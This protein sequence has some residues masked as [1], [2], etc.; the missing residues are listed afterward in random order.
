MPVSNRVLY[1]HTAVPIAPDEGAG[2]APRQYLE[3]VWN[4]CDAL[5][6]SKSWVPSRDVVLPSAS[7]P[8]ED[9]RTIVIPE[10]ELD[11]RFRIVASREKPSSAFQAFAY[12][13]H[14]VF[15]TVVQ[16]DPRSSDAE[17]VEWTD[18]LRQWNDLMPGKVPDGALGETLVFAAIVTDNS[19]LN[20]PDC[21]YEAISKELANEGVKMLPGEYTTASGFVLWDGKD[22]QGRRVIA[23]LAEKPAARELDEF[24]EHDV[25][26]F[27]WYVHRRKPAPFGQYL[28]DASKV[29]YE[30]AAYRKRQALMRAANA[31][32]EKQI[33]VVLHENA[34]LRAMERTPD[35]GKATTH[36]A[37]NHPNTTR[38]LNAQLEVRDGQ[39]G[40]KGLAM[41]V[42]RLR[43]LR[44][45]LRIATRNMAMSRPDSAH[46][47][48]SWRGDLFDRD[49]DRAEWLQQQIEY[50]IEYAQ[51]TLERAEASHALTTLRVEQATDKHNHY[52]DRVLL[53]HS[54]TAG[55]LVGALTLVQWLNPET[56]QRTEVKVA[57]AVTFAAFLLAF[58][59]A[60]ARWTLTYRRLDQGAVIVFGGLFSWLVVT[61][62]WASA[63]WWAALFVLVGLSLG[64]GF[65]R[66]HDDSFLK[67]LHEHDIVVAEK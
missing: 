24:V 12:V 51:A 50:D 53:V 59:L 1:V 11:D 41:Q 5:L 38:L 33:A 47:A 15:G 8:D 23:V 29:S 61:L 16:L 32:V 63:G 45:T 64:Y 22:R 25:D 40:E 58:P 54:I 10:D 30:D 62:I 4:A 31:K 56:P 7:P 28:V 39:L 44:N 49:V 43:E 13:S 65:V 66:W 18:L 35:S 17:Q 26:P 42:A 20:D 6:M 34:R 3:S 46:R 52:Q 19:L 55:M 48:A 37:W 9:L 36:S 60:V 21:W 27:L 2:D 57:L 14:D 67:R